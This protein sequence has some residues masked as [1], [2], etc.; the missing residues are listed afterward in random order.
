MSDIN[1][2]GW[3][4]SHD[5]EYLSSNDSK[6]SFYRCRNC[7]AFF[8]HAYDR[9]PDIFKALKHDGE[10]GLNRFPD[11]CPGAKVTP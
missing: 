7:G 6:V 3:G 9:I 8:V 11:Q 5:W 1:G 2:K 10:K 4:S